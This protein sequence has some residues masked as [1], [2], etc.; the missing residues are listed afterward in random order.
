MPPAN[1]HNPVRAKSSD[2]TYSLVEFD[3]DFPDHDACLVWLWK[4]RYAAADGEHAECPKCGNVCRFKRYKTKQRRQTWTCTGCG[5]HVQPTAGTIFA[6][7]STSLRLWF[8]A[9]HLITSTR[10]GISAKQLERELGV[11]YKTAWRMF[12]LIRNQVMVDDDPLLVGDVEADETFIG[13]K[14]KQSQKRTMHEHMER[15]AVV[16]GAV[17]R[18]GRIVA[19]VIPTQLYSHSNVRR[20]VLEGSNLYTDQWKGYGQLRY[21]YHHRTIDHSAKIYAMGDVH[22]QTIDGFFGLFKSGLRG[23]HHSV[24]KRWLQ[25][26][27]NEWT[28]RYNHRFDG[29]QQFFSLL[30][31]AARP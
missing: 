19:K 22:T 12:N 1:R 20:Y 29:E 24:S 16:F 5:H 4:Q 25:G 9:M 30:L 3:R 14:P 6:R 13:G 23:A 21:S 26:Y 7:S 8:K 28:W 15:K 18:S 31:R 2:S 27:L 11:N 17:E 10:C